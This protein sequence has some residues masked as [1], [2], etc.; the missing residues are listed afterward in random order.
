MFDRLFRHPGSAK[1]LSETSPAAPSEQV[2]PVKTSSQA[3]ATVGDAFRALGVHHEEL[4]SR[5]EVA[6]NALHS[7][8]SASSEVESIF[9]DFGQIAQDLHVTNKDLSEARD[10][11][12]KERATSEGLRSRLNE[13][14]ST[15][16]KLQTRFE[17]V[18]AQ[19][20]LM[21]NARADLEDTLRLS[22]SNL[23]EKEAQTR[24]LESEVASLRNALDEM[25]NKA[26]ALSQTLARSEK[27]NH[28][29]SEERKI[30]Q[31]RLD[32]ES[33]EKIRFQA[34][35]EDV[36]SSMTTQRNALASA[37]TELEKARDR[38]AQLE[39]RHS[40]LLGEREA[41][42]SSLDTAKALHD[43]EAT[44]FSIK[45][46]AVSSRAR[47]AEHLLAKTRDEQ[48]SAYREQTS[49]IETLRQVR[50]LEA[51]IESLRQELAVAQTRNRDLE[52]SDSATKERLEDMGQKLR[53]KQ[54]IIEQAYD[55]LRNHQEVIESIQSRY[56]GE[57]EKLNEQIVKLTEA[58]ERERTDRVYLEGALK[59]A[60]RDRSYL[61]GLL[62]KQKVLKSDDPAVIL[63]EVEPDPEAARAFEERLREERSTVTELRP[64]PSKG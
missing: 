1:L 49:Y 60:R 47:L 63:Q 50:G 26:D 25:R 51:N 21:A 34:L 58:A 32:F 12:V 3:A 40:E 19:H 7:L 45:L 43:T 17:E 54:L 39:A 4:R 52:Q 46:E 55:K 35:H 8:Q 38:I 37:G 53:D 41:L 56:A 13:T 57:A 27:Q 22:Q 29:T 33:A 44:N 64:P 6:V 14:Q 16:A 31:A 48:R 42:L 24:A 30:L 15:Y 2:R 36:V 23:K 61:Q 9:I 10:G 11:L 20:E 28:E 18:A 59:T 5:C 62:I